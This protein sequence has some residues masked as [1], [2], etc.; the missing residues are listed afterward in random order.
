VIPK[1]DGSDSSLAAICYQAR[2]TRDPAAAIKVLEPLTHGAEVEKVPFL[3]LWADLQ[4]MAG[5]KA[6]GRA[7]FER[8]RDTLEKLAQQ[9]PGNGELLGALA[10]SLSELGDGDAALRALDK[11]ADL[12]AGD[13]RAES[14]VEDSRARVL[15]RFGE[16]EGAISSVE[17]ILANPSDGAPPLTAALL[18]L[19][20]DFD[21]LRGD[22]RFQKLCEEKKP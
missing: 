9:Q 4:L 14:Q 22:P 5:K 10:F 16:K 7:M 20:P 19:D 2:L 18:R 6:E 12:S 21:N 13:A 15:A 1:I 17:R 11:C 3:L 8:G